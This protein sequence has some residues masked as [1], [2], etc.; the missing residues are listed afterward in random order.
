MSV[1]QTQN[2]P[3]HFSHLGENYFFKIANNFGS[4]NIHNAQ[5]EDVFIG[6]TGVAYIEKQNQRRVNPNWCVRLKNGKEYRYGT[7]TKNSTE[8]GLWDLN[9]CNH[10]KW[11]E[12][13]DFYYLK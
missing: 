10:Y 11:T 1:N 3:W 4:V 8:P 7:H 6:S 12:I 2:D 13:K 9:R 5:I